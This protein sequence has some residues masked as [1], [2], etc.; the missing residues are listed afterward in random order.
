MPETRVVFYREADGQAP[1]VVWLQELLKSN[2]RAWANCRAR[3]ELWFSLATNS[4]G[5]RQI[6]CETAFMNCALNRGMSN[7]GCFTFFTAD[8]WPSSHMP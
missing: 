3:V 2:A 1:V 8:N 4:G 7:I 5:L 6:I